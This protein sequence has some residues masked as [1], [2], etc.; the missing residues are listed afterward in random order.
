[1]DPNIR[2]AKSAAAMWAEDRASQDLG[3]VLE[4]VGPG[5][6]TLSMRV[7]PDMANGHGICHGGYLFTLAD[8]AFAFA[9]NSY[10]RATVARHNAITYLAPAQ[11]DEAL[12]ATAREVDRTGRSGVYDVEITGKGGRRLALF[13]GESREITGQ[14]FNEEKPAE[15]QE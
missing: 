12:T 4:H 2:A 1:M 11:V 5:T 8:S 3:M 9:C 7:R 10:N 14:H 13:R 15:A 6:A